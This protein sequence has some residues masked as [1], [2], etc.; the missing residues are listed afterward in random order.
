MQSIVTEGKNDDDIAKH[1]L[2]SSFQALRQVV[3]CQIVF[4]ASD[5]NYQQEHISGLNS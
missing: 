2:G 5:A 3:M 4:E 1:C